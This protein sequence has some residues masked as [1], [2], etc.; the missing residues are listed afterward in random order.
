MLLAVGNDGQFARFCES[1]EHPEW[2]GDIRFATNTLRVKN[3][4]ALIPQMQALTRTRTTAQWVA[5]LEKR[6]VPCGPINDIGQAFEDA[7]VQARGLVVK[8]DLAPDVR[9]Q[10]SIASIASVAS[11]M[12]LMDNP[13]VLHRAPPALG[14]HTN[15]VLEGLGWEASAIEN[16]R[17]AGVV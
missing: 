16:L 4:E 14:E 12:R 15:E 2:A 8:Q 11:P 13:P 17:K 10:T 1:V 6:A 9:A 3:R 7:Q 5:L